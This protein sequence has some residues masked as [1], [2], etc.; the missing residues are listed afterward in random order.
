MESIVFIVL[1]LIAG[2]GAG[3]ASAGLG[4]G[5]GIIMVPAFL[6][7]VPGMDAHTAKGTSL[8][9]IIFIALPNAWLLNRHL[10]ARPWRLAGLMAS[11]SIIG[12]YSGAWITA[13]MSEDAVLWI[14][15]ALLG[16]LALRTFC[17][18]PRQVQQEDL[19]RRNVAPVLIGLLAGVVGGATGTGG[20]LVLVPLALYAGLVTNDRVVGLSNMVIVMTS[21]AGTLAHLRAPE[22]HLSDWTVGQVYFPVV[23]LAILGARFGSILGLRINAMLTLPRRRVTM[24]IVLFMIAL[25]LF[26]R[27][28]L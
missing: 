16:G 15:I 8:F 5:G 11:G 27:L 23:P 17:L 2:A 26:F 22:I 7:F 6:T 20:G 4:L 13:L 1:M 24:G 12:G 21:I 14:F 9:I 19:R 28:M 3:I 25:R 18:E 10:P